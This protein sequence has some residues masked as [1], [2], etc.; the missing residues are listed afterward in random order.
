MMSEAYPNGTHYIYSFDGRLLAEYDVSGFWI[1]DYIYF[2]GQL[3]AEYRAATPQPQYYFYASDQINSTRIVT[4]S[5]GTV[6]YSAAH[7]PYGGIQQTWVTNFDPELKFSGKPRD[8]ESELDYF[9][10]RYYDRAQYRFLSADS[11]IDY[12][13]V[14]SNPQLWNLYTYCRSNPIVFVDPDGNFNVHFLPPVLHPNTRWGEQLIT[15]EY[16]IGVRGGTAVGVNVQVIIENGR[17]TLD[18]K[19][20][21]HIYIAA[22]DSGML[23]SKSQT[24]VAR[25]EDKHYMDVAVILLLNGTFRRIENQLRANKISDEQAKELVKKAIRNAEKASK[26]ERDNYLAMLLEIITD[27]LPENHVVYFFSNIAS[28]MVLH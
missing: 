8:A 18:I 24:D 11:A 16:F 13:E 14:F 3:V 9:G 23:G 15:G 28:W 7:E 26:K 10:A 5:T 19:I 6:V 2:G 25:H 22:T 4:D 21:F 17:K 1:R 20:E 12:I 27:W